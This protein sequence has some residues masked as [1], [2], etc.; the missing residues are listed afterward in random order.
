MNNYNNRLKDLREDRDLTQ[1]QVA[2]LLGT[3][4][5][6]Y[7]KYERGKIVIPLDRAFTLADFYDVSLDYLAGR[8]STPN[9][10]NKT[11]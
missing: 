3:T 10:Y 11:E 8:I 5:Q 4:Q 9:P 2:K 6:H 1:A 7:G